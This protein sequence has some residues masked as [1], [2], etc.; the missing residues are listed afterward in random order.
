MCT[1][2]PHHTESHSMNVTPL[3]LTVMKSSAIIEVVIAPFYKRLRL[4]KGTGVEKHY[5]ACAITS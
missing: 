4:F 3:T 2:R 5:N 1:N